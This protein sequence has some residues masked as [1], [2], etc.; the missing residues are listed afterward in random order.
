MHN[1]NIHLSAADWVRQIS[2]PLLEGWTNRL[3]L[4]LHPG[5]EF[6]ERRWPVWRSINVQ[7]EQL[8]ENQLLQIEEAVFYEYR[9]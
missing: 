1:A 9:T 7:L 2:E 5:H 8:C 6:A 3:G 4:M